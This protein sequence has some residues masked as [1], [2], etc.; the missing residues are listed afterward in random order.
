MIANGDVKS[1][2]RGSSKQLTDIV[3]LLKSLPSRIKAL[4]IIV[5][6]GVFSIFLGYISVAP[7][8]DLPSWPLYKLNA[9]VWQSFEH[10]G[11]HVKPYHIRIMTSA[12]QHVESRALYIMAYLEIPD[13][14]Q[15]AETPLSCEEVKTLIDKRGRFGEISLPFL[16]RILHAAAHFDLLAETGHEK[17]SLTPLS[18]YLT[19]SHPKSLKSFVQLYS[20]DE[21]LVIST[22]LSRS[23]FT[24]NSGFKET[25]RKELLD[26]MKIDPIFQEI[27]DAGLADSSRLHAPAI[28]SDYPSF[29][30][31]KHICD[32]GGGVGSFL[33]SILDY[34]SQ[35]IRG[36]NLDLP[37]VIENAK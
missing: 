34:Y 15:E 1:K 26:Q 12:L 18:E 16:C 3:S 37:D 24:G 8:T 28:I 33:Y 27:Y 2:G 31:C 10:W 36:T 9:K 19:S 35:G 20:G 13:V 25:Y 14:L 5:A 23:I 11:Q 30:S 7:P 22:S 21:A 32:M 29:S 6:L 4:H 17:Y